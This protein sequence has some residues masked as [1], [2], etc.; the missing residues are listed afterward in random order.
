M[1]DRDRLTLTDQGAV[2][3]FIGEDARRL[4][5]STGLFRDSLT[6]SGER[7]CRLK[8]LRRRDGRDVRAAIAVVVAH[9]EL[10]PSLARAAGCQAA[11]ERLLAAHLTEQR[12][13]AYDSVERVLADLPSRAEVSATLDGAFGPQRRAYRCREPRPGLP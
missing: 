7:P 10:G 11:F 3:V 4:S 5:V 9:G 8:G 2:E 13:I 1:H 6:V 12:W